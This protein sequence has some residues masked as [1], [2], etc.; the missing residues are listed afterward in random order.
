MKEKL[1]VLFAYNAMNI[2]G[3]TTSLLSVLNHIDYDK[4]DVDLLLN[5]NT[6]PLLNLIPSKVNL[7]KPSYKYTNKKQEYIHRFLSPKF[8]WHFLVSKL[9]I[10][11]TG[12]PIHGPQYREWK[13]IEFQR[14]IEKEY[15]V[16]VAFLEGDRCKFV[17][18]HV[19]AKRK[20]AWIHTNY[21]DAKFD[22]K[23][24][25]RYYVQI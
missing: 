18:R 3:S 11:K 21:I 22:P 2:G 24:D 7:L 4:Y 23:Y 19:K 9:I 5:F 16:A 20:I 14:E 17:A 10:K 1:S 15:D 8:L 12:V 25:P 13:D 6:G